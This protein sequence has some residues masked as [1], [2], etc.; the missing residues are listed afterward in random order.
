[1]CGS[2][3]FPIEAALIACNTAPGLIKYP[4]LSQN[5]IKGQ[6]DLVQPV[7]LHWKDVDPN[8]WKEAWL[9]ATA[10]DNRYKSRRMEGFKPIIFGNDI[11]NKSIELAKKAA[12]TAGVDH[13]I[14]YF[15]M[16]ISEFTKIFENIMEQQ[17]STSMNNTMH[18]LNHHA[19]SSVIDNKEMTNEVK[20]VSNKSD[21]QSI[22]VV[23]NPPWDM[24]LSSDNNF[25]SR[26][27][28]TPKSNPNNFG[29]TN[30]RK[31]NNEMN[32]YGKLSVFLDKCQHHFS[33]ACYEKSLTQ[34]KIKA[35]AYV[36][37]GN[38]ELKKQ[39]DMPPNQIKKFYMANT[40]VEWLMY[41]LN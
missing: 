38:K 30:G 28:N 40:D 35:T 36:L 19:N 20:E 16:D 25:Q 27:Y 23:T 24:R 22:L 11:D 10:K 29:L 39:I 37:S 9:E 34:D 41:H 1:M 17:K 31:S 13:L 21:V 32:S 12:R 33:L 5:N 4:M 18:I 8:H 15:N 6:R 3:T 26:N 2:G 14:K 7:P